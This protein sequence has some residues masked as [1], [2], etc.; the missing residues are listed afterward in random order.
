MP[1]FNFKCFLVLR[2]RFAADAIFDWRLPTLLQP[3]LQ[4][5]FV[6]GA[7][8]TVCVD[9]QG[10]FEKRTL[11][12]RGRCFET[13]VQI[14]GAKNCL[15]RVREQ[16]LLVTAPGLFLA[17]AKPQMAAKLQVLR[18]RMNRRGAD[19]PRE[20]LGKLS[21]IPVRKSPAKFFA[22]H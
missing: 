5:R 8:Q 19:E 16:P 18:S 21:R 17:R 4:C 2:P 1:N 22:G 6:V 3:F 9:S 20:A 13:R 10:W 14:D 7:L 12:E 15:E 11:Q